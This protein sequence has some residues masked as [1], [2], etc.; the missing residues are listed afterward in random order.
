MTNR[1][2]AGYTT[3]PRFGLS[4]PPSQLLLRFMA[5]SNKLT[6]SILI[7]YGFF[8]VL[9]LAWFITSFVVGGYFNLVAFITLAVF[10]AQAYYKNRIANLVLGLIILPAS[11][12]WGLQFAYSGGKTGFD[13]F[14]NVM[15]LLSATSLA[16]S[17]VLVF[18]Y[19]KMSFGND[20]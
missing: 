8:I 19:L 18:G 13:T 12:F 10:S 9:A 5:E 17:I 11:I 2:T 4:L 16:M 1:T 7:A 15:L 20:N 3:Y 14:I 6:K